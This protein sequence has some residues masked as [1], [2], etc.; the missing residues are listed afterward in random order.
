MGWNINHKPHAGHWAAHAMGGV[1]SPATQ[2]CIGLYKD[3][4]I[5]AGVIFENWNGRSLVAHMAVNG[6]ITRRY[7]F[8]IFDYAFNRADVEKV[9]L[10]VQSTNAQSIKF[11]L[12]LGFQEEAKIRDAAPGGDI[13]L[14]TLAKQNCRFLGEKYGKAVTAARA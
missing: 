5:R 2:T 14:F 6:R 11:V 13:L 3:D 7:L 9:I 8:V 10:P 1:F 4:V 12:N